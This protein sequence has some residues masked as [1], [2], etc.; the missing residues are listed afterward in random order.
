MPATLDLSGALTRFKEQK[1]KA[2]LHCDSLQ[3]L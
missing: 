1:P 2:H 3:S